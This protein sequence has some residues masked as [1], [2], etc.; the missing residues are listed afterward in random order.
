MKKIFSR[1]RRIT[2]L[3]YSIIASKPFLAFIYW[4][5]RIY[6]ATLRVTVENERCWLDYLDRGGRVILSGWHQQFFIAVR[7]F[8]KYRK[9]HPSVM[10]SRSEDGTV[11]AGVARRTGWQVVR[12]CSLEGGRE[13]LEEVI[14]RLQEYGL[15]AHVVDGPLGPAG[16]VKKGVIII[17]QSADAVI[18]P[19]W[20]EADRAWHVN[21]WDRFMIPKPFARLTLR[22]GDMIPAPVTD[23]EEEIET[24]RRTLETILRP[25]LK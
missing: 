11:A 13:A 16:I 5:V 3:K 23:R 18:V 25:A 8:R 17:A 14:L 4:F 20:A 12:G 24:R 22:F 21:S 9:Y 7:K 6:S 1:N 2:R 10:V 15:A 19:V